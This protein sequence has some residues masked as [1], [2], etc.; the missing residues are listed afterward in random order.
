MRA[1]VLGGLRESDVGGAAEF[2]HVEINGTEEL[3]LH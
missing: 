3:Q 1:G 2:Q